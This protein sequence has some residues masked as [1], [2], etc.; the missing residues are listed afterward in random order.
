MTF[1]PFGAIQSR[2]AVPPPVVQQQGLRL[3]HST[4]RRPR[5]RLTPPGFSS[6]TVLGLIISMSSILVLSMMKRTH[7]LS[8]L[9]VRQTRALHVLVLAGNNA[10]PSP[11]RSCWPPRTASSAATSSTN[12][13]TRLYSF[14]RFNDNKDDSKNKGGF[15]TKIKDKAKKYLPFLR[16]EQ[17]Q[18]AAIEKQRVKSELKSSIQEIFRDTPLPIRAMG[19]LVASLLGSAVS[20][21]AQAASQQSD[22][23]DRYYG[24][25]VAA[26]TS[27]P[28]V[29]SA[30]GSPVQ[31][32]PI[33]SRSSS[34]TSI[35][36]RSLTRVQLGFAVSGSS[37]RGL[38]GQAV[39]SVQ[40]TNDDNNTD[41]PSTLQ[42]QLNTGQVLS[43]PMDGRRSSPVDKRFSSS[44]SKWSNSNDDDS[45]IEAEIIDKKPSGR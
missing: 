6:F 27:N 16:T 23:V 3:R 25:A 10:R 44:T 45:V 15:W 18:N 12:S 37:R 35:N 21:L 32:G 40:T 43:V 39:L 28:A 38:V 4:T 20:D 14:N 34:T 19:S 13:C 7:A 5:R 41:P 9:R 11:P 26:L 31:V 42:L 30:L 29:Q 24:Q 1:Q 8:I 17:E 33:T 2:I 36:G 22:L